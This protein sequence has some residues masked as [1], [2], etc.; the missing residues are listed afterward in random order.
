MYLSGK[1]T[2]SA[3]SVPIDLWSPLYSSYCILIVC[4][5]E[6]LYIFRFMF[7]RVL[8]H[9]LKGCPEGHSI[10]PFCWDHRHT[11]N[12]WSCASSDCHGVIKL[13]IESFLEG[14]TW[15]YMYIIIQASLTHT[16]TI[17]TRG[18]PHPIVFASVAEIMSYYS[19]MAKQNSALTKDWV[20]AGPRPPI[21]M[22]S[23][24][25]M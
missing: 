18:G 16:A 8:S 7:L 15:Q 4:I 25:F 22:C 14:G 1:L 11:L 21:Q 24:V 13:G 9:S 6:K 10:P 20:W 3:A 19:F 12:S 2:H 5:V 17:N 23:L